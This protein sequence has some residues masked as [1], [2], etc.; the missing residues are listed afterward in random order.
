[1]AAAR[2]SS[3]MLVTGLNRNSNHSI[4]LSSSA[5]GTMPTTPKARF[6][7]PFISG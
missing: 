7:L 1:M 4:H 2:N 6:T 3:E 5:K